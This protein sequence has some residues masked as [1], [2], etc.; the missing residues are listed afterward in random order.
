[1]LLKEIFKVFW[2]F[3]LPKVVKYVVVVSFL[4]LL[5]VSFVFLKLKNF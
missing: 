2:G 5:V 1:M 4:F 3:E